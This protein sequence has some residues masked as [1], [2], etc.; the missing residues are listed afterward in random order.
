M[1]LSSKHTSTLAMQIGFNE[2]RNTFEISAEFA[3]SYNDWI[4]MCFE[5]TKANYNANDWP[6]FFFKV[7]PPQF[8][9]QVQNDQ[10]CAAIAKTSKSPLSISFVCFPTNSS[11]TKDRAVNNTFLVNL[12]L[13]WDIFHFS[14]KHVLFPTFAKTITLVD[15]TQLLK[16]VPANEFFKDIIDNSVSL[17]TVLRKISNIVVEEK[18]EAVVVVKTKSDSQIV[19]KSILKTLLQIENLTITDH[20][21]T[22]KKVK[23]SISNLLV[24]SRCAR[25]FIKCAKKAKSQCFAFKIVLNTCNRYFDI[26]KKGV[27]FTQPTLL[28]T[29]PN[30]EQKLEI[31]KCNQFFNKFISA[32]INLNEFAIYTVSTTPHF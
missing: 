23:F 27:Y 14:L 21:A 12:F 3:Q 16:T 9:G 11:N 10:I 13:I 18:A 1:V 5:F 31:A 6:V 20:S 22:F 26:D 28:V 15:I 2:R 32:Y 7:N 17:L 30:G 19:M 8:S 24:I 29:I 25:R 4:S